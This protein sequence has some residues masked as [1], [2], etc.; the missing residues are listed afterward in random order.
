MGKE[1]KDHRLFVMLTIIKKLGKMKEI[2]NL[3]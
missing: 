1:S 2:T 3:N